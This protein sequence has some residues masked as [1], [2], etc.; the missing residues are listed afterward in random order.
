MSGDKEKDE[1]KGSAAG[2][3][4][5]NQPAYGNEGYGN[6]PAYSQPAYSQPGYGQPVSYGD[7][8]GRN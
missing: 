7:P 8:Q 6:Q 3:Q 4:T 5:Y 2:R 1:E